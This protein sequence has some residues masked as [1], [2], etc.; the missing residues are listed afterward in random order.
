MSRYR[1]YCPIARG[2]EIMAER[3][4]PLI[5][6]NLLWGATTFTDIANGVPTMSRSM[7]V[8]RLGQLEANGIIERRRRN[9]GR[10][11]DYLLTEA[12]RGLAPVIDALGAWAMRWLDVTDEHDDPGFA[13]WA[14]ARF[15]IVEDRLPDRRTVVAFDFVEERS[16]HRFFWLLIDGGEAEVCHSDPGGDVDV[17]VVARSEPFVRW[18]I[19]ERS[20][21]ALL[22]SGDLT[23]SGDRGL[24]RALPR[25]HADAPTF[26]A[27]AR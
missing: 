24:A 25:W 12:G 9:G 27:P 22:R 17:T 1:Q 20:W 5:V 7:L 23:V 4:T 8:R 18:H 3:W 13:L 6:R 11:S 26:P 19:G 14:W 15:H 16:G 10:G 21:T 2:S